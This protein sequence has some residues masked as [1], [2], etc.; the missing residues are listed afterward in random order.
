SSVVLLLSSLVISFGSIAR[1]GDLYL[2]DLLKL[3]PYH[4]AWDAMLKGEKQVAPWVIAF[5]KTYDGVSDPLRN[6]TVDGDPNIVGWVCKPHDCGGNE[7]Y[8][9]FAP[10]ARQA[11]GMLTTDGGAPR[12]LG[13]PGDTEKGVLTE[14]AK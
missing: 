1:A 5:G 6:V 13:K 11:W 7:L 3:K 4:A 9:L 12:W 14:A 8:V 10:D 2:F